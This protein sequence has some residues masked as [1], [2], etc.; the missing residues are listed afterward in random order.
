M[1]D[2][3][4]DDYVVQIQ[5]VHPNLL[6]QMFDKAILEYDNIKVQLAKSMSLVADSRNRL[7]DDIKNLHS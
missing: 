3:E 5:D 6:I 4:L 1:G 7:I 2:F